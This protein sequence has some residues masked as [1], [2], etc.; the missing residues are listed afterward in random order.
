MRFPLP[1]GTF[2]TLVV[3]E[4]DQLEL[5]KLSQA[6]TREALE[7]YTDFRDVRGGVLDKQRWRAVKSRKGVTSYR[8]LRLR[9]HDG[10]DQAARS[11]RSRYDRR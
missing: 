7:E 10:V 8:D 2:P 1:A 3:S 11:D 5:D 4:E 9:R 6:F